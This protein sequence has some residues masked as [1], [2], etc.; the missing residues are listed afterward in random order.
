MGLYDGIACDSRG[1]G[2]MAQ[3]VISS[4]IYPGNQTQIIEEYRACW[5]E[6][7]HIVVLWLDFEFY[8]NCSFNS[9]LQHSIELSLMNKPVGQY[10][11]CVMVQ[12][13]NL[14]TKR[15]LKS[16]SA[17]YSILYS[18]LLSFSVWLTCSLFV[19]LSMIMLTGIGDCL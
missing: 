10:V 17:L 4:S 15:V 14:D 3:E 19:I 2:L 7:S 18:L 13:T 8:W 11:S 9:L 5:N 12:S 6:R 16:E 1:L